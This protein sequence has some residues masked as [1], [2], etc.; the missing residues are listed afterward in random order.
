MMQC[1]SVLRMRRN[2][3]QRTQKL[4]LTIDVVFETHSATSYEV[5][6]PFCGGNLNECVVY[7]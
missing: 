5:Y 4:C 6:I 1:V 3:F 2:S 7:H